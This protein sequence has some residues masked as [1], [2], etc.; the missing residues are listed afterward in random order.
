M[1]WSMKWLYNNLNGSQSFADRS[2]LN[3]QAYVTIPFLILFAHFCR[4][5][6]QRSIE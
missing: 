5:K 1:I 4:F 6:I 3:D 2:D